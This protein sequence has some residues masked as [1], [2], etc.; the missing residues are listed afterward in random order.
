VKA[1]IVGGHISDESDEDERVDPTAAFYL[2]VM[3]GEES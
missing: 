3:D 2:V 1:K